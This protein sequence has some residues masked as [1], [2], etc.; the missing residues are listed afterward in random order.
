MALNPRLR[1]FLLATLLL[2]ALAV[3]VWTLSARRTPTV[4]TPIDAPPVVETVASPNPTPRTVAPSPVAAMPAPNQPP[5]GAS[6]SNRLLIP[7]AG[8]S[9]SELRDTYAEARSEGRTHNALDIIAARGTP[10]VACADGRIVKLFNSEKG[11]IT[12]YQ[13]SADERMVYYY[14]HL[15]GYAEGLREQAYARRGDVLGYVGDTGNATP[16]NYHLHFEV[17]LIS[18]PKRHW[19]GTPVNPYPLLNGHAPAP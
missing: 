6:N 8:V 12:I 10:V 14:A 19:D 17:S 16:G 1:V 15:E 9:A 7:V 3:L 13:L 5:P 11:G 18:D 4:V 2:S